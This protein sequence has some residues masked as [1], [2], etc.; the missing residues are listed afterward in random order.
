MPTMTDWLSRLF[1]AIDA[2]PTWQLYALVG[3]VLLLETT[4]GVGLVTPGEVALLAAAT[5]VDT[6]PQYAGLVVVATVASLF[7]QVG[8]YLLGRRLG[9]RIRGSWVGR[10]I[11]ESNWL[12]AEQVLRNGKGRALVGSRFL[13]VAH[14]LVPV[15][16][17]TLR[18]PPHRFSRYT[19]IGTVL[20]A[21][22]YVGLGTAASATL[23]KAAHLIGPTFTSV[24]VLAII[25]A[26]VVRHVRR[27]QSASEPEPVG[28]QR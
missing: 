6:A 26:L 23:R 28:P 20:W 2:I 4:V 16:A 11:G 3:A 14:S 5:T 21:L 27:A 7:G 12:K 13:A 8:G 10:R 17:G 25:V 19:A 22:F 1:Q 18:M 9:D 24:L 15:V